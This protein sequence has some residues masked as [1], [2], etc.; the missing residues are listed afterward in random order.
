[1]A[2]YD[3][4]VLQHEQSR[5]AFLE[6]QNQIHSS[7]FQHM[8]QELNH[9]RNV[10]SQPNQPPI[11]SIPNSRPNINLPH[12]PSF[13]GNPG[14]LYS[15]KIRLSQYLR[16]NHLNYNDSESQL[17]YAGSL[18]SGTAGQWY[19]S[20]IDPATLLLPTTY[21]LES[22][23]LELEDFFGGGVTLQTRERSLI[24]LRQTGTVSELAIAFQNI[25]NTFSPRWADHPLIFTFS[26]KLKEGVRFELMSRG[27]VP[28]TF[29]AYIAVA[30]SVEHNQAAASQSRSQQP[31]PSPRPPFAPRPLALP[32]PPRHPVPNPSQ[33]TPMDLDGTR[34]PRGP[35]TI[36]ERRRRSDAGLC[37]YCGQ[38]GHVI[39]TCPRR[40][41]VRGVYQA[42]P[43]YLPP[44]AS[45]H[46]PPG[47]QLIP[48]SFPTP[49]TQ[50][51]PP[52]LPAPPTL[53]KN[54]RPSQQ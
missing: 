50:V 35:L 14:E 46:P 36:D 41:Q 7:N 16:G 53:P 26:Q 51:P 4:T 37:A 17:L 18:L 10:I 23:L 11:H 39:A 27:S 40:F 22:F 43:G 33:P 1:M 25:T 20:L 52:A 42:P 15:F 45:Y 32:P 30:I 24:L 5:V 28:T 2:E 31:P 13:S 21:T 49:W 47:F 3:E 34:G 9:L 8:A 44:P 29:Q 19:D 48:I 6:H 38:P 54:D 12:P